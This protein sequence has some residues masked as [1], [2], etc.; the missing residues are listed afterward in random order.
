MNAHHVSGDMNEIL[1]PVDSATVIVAGEMVRL[2]TD[3]AKRLST[4]S[5]AGT[6]AQN[7]AAAHDVFLGIARDSSQAGQTRPIRVA[8][9]GVFDMDAVSATYEIGALVGPN[10]TGSG[11]A[12]GVSDTQVVAVST[13]ANQAIGRVAKRAVTATRIR[14][15]IFS[16]VLRAGPQT[17]YPNLSPP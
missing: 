10:G 11:E 7:Q 4:M 16:S 13:Q 1:V 5:D 9:S 15:E 6:E 2:D 14:V 8:T 3:D 17:I 12:V